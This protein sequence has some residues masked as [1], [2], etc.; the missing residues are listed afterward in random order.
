[1]LPIRPAPVVDNPPPSSP[2]GETPRGEGRGLGVEGP[3]L[4]IENRIWRSMTPRSR[5]IG[6]ESSRASAEGLEGC[7]PKALGWK[8]EGGSRE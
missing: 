1:M 3:R 7:G 8:L 6:D 5:V 4:R 2:E